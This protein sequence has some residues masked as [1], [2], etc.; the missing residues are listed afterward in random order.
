MINTGHTCTWLKMFELCCSSHSI[1]PMFRGTLLNTPFSS[2]FSPP[3]LRLA[4][5][6]MTTLSLLC[7]SASSTSATPQ[8]WLLSGRLAEQ[9]PL[10]PTI[11][12]GKFE[13]RRGWHSL[14]ERSYSR[15]RSCMLVA[16]QRTAPAT[17]SNMLLP[18]A[19]HQLPSV[20]TATRVTYG[21]THATGDT[22]AG[23]RVV[24]R[25]HRD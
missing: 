14:N 21:G 3:S 20:R 5:S 25:S 15:V 2:P 4:P 12:T 8:E 1:S 24:A 13:N 11:T 19:Y 10:A 22:L 16:A 23:W 18:K 17:T 6:P 7:L 9:S